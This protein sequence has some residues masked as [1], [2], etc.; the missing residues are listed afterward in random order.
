MSLFSK[1]RAGRYAA[2]MLPSLLFCCVLATARKAGAEPTNE[3]LEPLPPIPTPTPAPSPQPPPP[4]APAASP[5]AATTPPSSTTCHASS[6]CGCACLAR[7]CNASCGCSE[8]P[9]VSLSIVG[10]KFQ[11]TSVAAG[12]ATD[13]AFSAALAGTVDSYALDGTTHAWMQ[14]ALGGGEAGFDG[15][16][17]GTIDIGHRIDVA[18]EHG[19]FGRIGFDG[20]IQGNDLLFYSHLEIPRLTLGYQ[21]LEGKTVL[22]AGLRGGPIITGRLKPGAEGRRSLSRALEWGGFAAAQIDLVRVDVS[23]MRAEARQTLN[24]TPVDVGHAKVCLVGAKFGGCFDGMIFRGDADMGP[25]AGGVRS[26]T[27]MFLGV[28][29]GVVGW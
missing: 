8:Q 9:K 12:A 4:Y 17:A 25:A 18:K 23:F 2:A 1:R 21:Y 14:F 16:L 26:T 22:E 13:S 19:P 7:C 5:A 10:A 3:P 28:T 29:I 6:T 11:G 27:S 20:R 24:E 15:A